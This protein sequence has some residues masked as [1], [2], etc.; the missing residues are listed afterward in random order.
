MEKLGTKKPGCNVAA[1]SRRK[2]RK[3]MFMERGFSN[4][5]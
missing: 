3:E 1:N 2:V 5:R 4:P